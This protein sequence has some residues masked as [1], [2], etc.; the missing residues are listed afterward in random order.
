MSNC[1]DLWSTNSGAGGK[2]NFGP[3]G[4]NR[5]HVRCIKCD[6]RTWYTQPQWNS[7][8]PKLKTEQ[9]RKSATES[10]EEM[11]TCPDC[12][13]VEIATVEHSR[14]FDIYH[15][16]CRCGYMITESEWNKAFKT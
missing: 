15:H 6:A 16:E 5:M 7:M 13:S 1:S 11:I 2:P 3:D 12:L 4:L 10:H 8:Q 14:P 9:P